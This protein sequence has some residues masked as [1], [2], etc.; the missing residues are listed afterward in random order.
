MNIQNQKRPQKETT[1]I[2]LKEIQRQFFRTQLILIIS[3]AVILGL[4]GTF[5]NLQF[6]TEKRDRN[7]QNVA[8]AIARSPILMESHTYDENDTLILQEYLDSLKETLDDIDVI[9]IVNNNHIR[10]YHST[11]T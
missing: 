7:L 11:H 5:I 9:S 6:E 8:T 1:K 3:L 10:V 2:S 4:A